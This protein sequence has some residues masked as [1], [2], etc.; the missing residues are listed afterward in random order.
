[1]RQRK[2]HLTASAIMILL[3]V[4]GCSTGGIEYPIAPDHFISEVVR[5]QNLL[6]KDLCENERSPIRRCLNL[7]IAECKLEVKKR[8][9]SCIG[10]VTSRWRSPYPSVLYKPEDASAFYR[11]LLACVNKGVGISVLMHK[12]L[13]PSCR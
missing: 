5:P 1:M 7:T 4:A 6:N 10:E 11:E 9:D 8:E 13:D 3:L 2:S 12:R